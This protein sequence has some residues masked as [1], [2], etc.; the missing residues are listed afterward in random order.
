[1]RSFSPANVFRTP[2]SMNRVESAYS[3]ESEAMK[4]G[5]LLLVDDDRRV[6]E[7]MADWLRSQGHRVDT[8]ASYAQAIAAVGKKNYDLVLA[9]IRLGDGAGFDLLAHCRQ[10][11]PTAA[12]ILLTGYGTVESAVEAVRAG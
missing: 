8:A 10:A 4:N 5:A 3:A 7:S 2:S 11:H 6:L 12:V 1:M 9:D